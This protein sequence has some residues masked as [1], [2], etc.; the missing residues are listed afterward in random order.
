MTKYVALLRGINVGGRIIKM[1]DLK[2]CFE[3]MGFENVITILQTGNVVFETNFTGSHPVRLELKE[4]IEQGLA[5][6]FGYS[7]KAQVFSA[8]DLKKIVED[9]PFGTADLGQHDYV[10]FLENGLGQALIAESYT[11]AKNE[12]VEAGSEVVYW[13]VNRGDTLK[14]PFAKFLSRAK[15]K[16]FNTNRNIKTLRKILN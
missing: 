13:R 7:A 8:R 9:Y 12:Q 3:D 4:K 1:M 5:K 14:S 2:I 16:D 10:I 6:T 15:Y 11:L